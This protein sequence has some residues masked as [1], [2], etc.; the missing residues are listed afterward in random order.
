MSNVTRTK[1]MPHPTEF[2]LD[3]EKYYYILLTL[4][5]VGYSVCCTVIVA[6]DTIYLALLQHT[7]GTLAILRYSN[8]G[9]LYLSIYKKIKFYYYVYNYIL[10]FNLKEIEIYVL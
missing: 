4:T 5:I 2:F 9:L 1:Q 8:F 6:T 3:V 7:C 10:T